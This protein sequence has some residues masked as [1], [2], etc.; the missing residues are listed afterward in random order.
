MSLSLFESD[1]LEVVTQTIADGFGN[2]ITL[3]KWGCCSIAETIAIDRVISAQLMVSEHKRNIVNAFLGLRLR[4]KLKN[5]DALNKAD[6]LLNSKGEPL[7]EPMIENLYQFVMNE[8]NRD[9]P[10]EQEL[11]IS[12]IN[13]RAVAIAYAKKHQAVVVTRADLEAQSIYYV[14]S[15]DDVLPNMNE[16]K[17]E[18]QL[19]YAIENFCAPEEATEGK[20]KAKGGAKA[21]QKEQTGIE[22]S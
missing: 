21:V 9:R 20:P 13:A 10:S 22:S 17:A 15:R 1:E 2:R 18:G 3:P 11:N 5:I 6:L 14:F 12:G 16:G 7:P 19:Y 4:D 8:Y